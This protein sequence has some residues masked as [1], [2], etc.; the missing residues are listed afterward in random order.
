MAKSKKD[1]A[2]EKKQP[3]HSEAVSPS[4]ATVSQGNLGA[5]TCVD[6][7]L[8]AHLLELANSKHA[9]LEHCEEKHAEDC[10]CS[11][12]S[13]GA[14]IPTKVDLIVLIDTS[15]S[16]RTKAQAIHDAAMTALDNAKK[17]CNVDLVPVFL[18]IEGTFVFG[19]PEFEFDQTCRNFLINK[20]CDKQ[21]ADPQNTPPAVQG[22][23][24]EGADSITDLCNCPNI[25]REGACRAIF[26][27]SDEPLNQGGPQGDDDIAA[28]QIAIA[29]A[30]ANNVKVFAHLAKGSY[31]KNKKTQND[32]KNLCYQTGGEPFIDEKFDSEPLVEKYE[33]LLEKAICQACGNCAT[34]ELP[35]VSPCFSVTWGD[36]DCDCMETN[37]FELLLI[38]AC[39]CY[40]NVAFH[41]LMIGKLT[42]LDSEGKEVVQLPD[43]TPSVEV[44]P[45][46]PICFGELPP[47][48]ENTPSCK[49]REIV[50]RTRGAIA[51]NYQ[52]KFE[53]VC[54]DVVNSFATEQCFTLN[55][56]KD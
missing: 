20:G 21:I 33:R 13:G 36:S 5:K 23:K 55:L 16:M 8:E 22:Y 35:A 48:S 31:N 25:W 2:G 37:D 9:Q 28:T 38:K 30:Q 46:G 41:N 29:A 52:L 56:C 50:I 10:P 53:N 17:S 4:T 15:G 19:D 54:F 12:P 7:T 11:S 1:L 26:Y 39:N 34:L 43:G 14:G 18:G 3:A 47:C 42:I 27:I 40:S 6:P 51:G 44:L 24:E 49:A 32:Y 45:S